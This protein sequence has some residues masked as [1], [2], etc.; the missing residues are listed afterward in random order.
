MLIPISLVNANFTYAGK[1]PQ[2]YRPQGQELPAGRSETLAPGTDLPEMGLMLPV[3][4][5]TE[6]EGDVR[7]RK[8][9]PGKQECQT[10]KHR[11][12]QDGSDDPGVSF[13]SPTKIDPDTAATTVRS[14]EHEHVVRERAAAKREGREVISQTV[15]IHTAVCPEC[16]RV[17]V[18]GGTTRTVTRTAQEEKQPDRKRRRGSFSVKV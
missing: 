3:T 6:A 9:L 12:Y 14:H 1:P 18:S 10:C 8:E 5:K 15:R 17:Y 4:G 2:Q 16:G 7:T 11:K 13:K